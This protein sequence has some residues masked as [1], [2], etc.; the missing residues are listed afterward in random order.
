MWNPTRLPRAHQRKPGIVPTALLAGLLALSAPAA[1]QGEDDED[2][3]FDAVLQM[4]SRQNCIATESEIFETFIDAGGDMWTANLIFTT[5]A[6]SGALVVVSKTPE[7]TY[8]IT[9]CQPQ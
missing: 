8:R 7:F 5:G 9:Q 2:D 4:A 6:E 3:P 1:A